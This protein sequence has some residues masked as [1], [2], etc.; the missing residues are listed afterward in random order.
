MITKLNL[1]TRP[2]R[3]RTTPYLISLIFLAL[4]VSGGILCFSQI[5][6]ANVDGD[7]LRV[8]AHSGQHYDAYQ[9][10]ADTFGTFE[11]DIYL[12]VTSVRGRRMELAILRVLGMSGASVRWS[13]AVQATVTALL[14]LIIGIPL[15]IAIGRRAWLGYAR[16]LD[17]VPMSVVPWTLLSIIVLAPVVVANVAVLLPAWMAARR[18]LG[19]DLRAG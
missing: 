17:V 10:L 11:N 13:I 18:R 1:A 12:L 4:A 5:P 6:K 15:G 16:N 19:S 3:N 7:L 8:Y 9:H 14:P 2:F